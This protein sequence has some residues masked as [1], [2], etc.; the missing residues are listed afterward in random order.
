LTDYSVEANNFLAT[1]YS[2]AQTTS[3]TAS[4]AADT[5]FVSNGDKIRPKVRCS[6][7]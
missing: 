3:V 4:A 6:H 2:G 5:R 1:L 7:D